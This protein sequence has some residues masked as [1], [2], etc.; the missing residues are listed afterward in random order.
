MKMDMHP[1]IEKLS[2][3]TKD[4]LNSNN[5]EFLAKYLS[6]IWNT[7]FEKKIH[8]KVNKLVNNLLY[9]KWHLV[10]YDVK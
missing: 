4:Y 3:D 5:S 10:K 6:K 2:K 9:I 1:E 7:F 8:G